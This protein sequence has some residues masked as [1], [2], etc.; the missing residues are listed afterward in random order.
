MTL[1]ELMIVLALIGILTAIALP[2]YQDYINVANMAKVTAH[3]DQAKRITSATFVKGHVQV[4]LGQTDKVPV[5][6]DEWIT[7]YNP[8]GVPAPGGGPA[9]V[10]GDAVDATGQIGITFTGVFPNTALV[11]ISLPSYLDVTG[12]TKTI[13][14]ALKP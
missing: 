7:I 1:I 8:T 14:S 13:S 2:V 12:Q 10:V 3:F 4:A 11:T 9:F 5:N 6:A